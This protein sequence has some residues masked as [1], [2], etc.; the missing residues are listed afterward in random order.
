MRL[1]ALVVGAVV[2]CGPRDSDPV[3]QPPAPDAG[4]PLRGGGGPSVA[5][6]P[7]DLWAPCAWLTGSPDD[8]DHHNLVM[9]YRGHLVLPWA[10][11][12]S[13]GGLSF[14]DVSDPCAP[15]KA[16][17]GHDPQ[18][19]E[20]HAIGF[21]HLPD[22][23]SAGDWAFVNDLQGM[24]TWDVTDLDA[25]ARVGRAIPTNEDGDPIALYPDSYTRVVLSLFLQY[26]WV[27]LASAD[28]GV[29]VVD[30]SDPADPQVVHQHVFDPPLRAGGVFALGN[31]LLVSSA[32]GS[33]AEVLDISDPARPQ[34][35]PGGRF[36][37]TGADGVAAEA[38]HGNLS[39]NLALF[40][41]KSG[42]GGV[43]VY[44]ISDPER[45]TRLGEVRHP[46]GNGGYV[47]Y[48]E[49]FL[50]T[51]ESSFGSVLDARDLSAITEV[52][53]VVIEG[54]LDT[55][56]PYG[57]V[58]IAAVDDKPAQVDGVGLASGVFP[59]SEAVDVTGPV[60]LAVDPP[61]GRVGVP[62]TGRIGVGFNEPVEPSTAHPG[63]IRV[64]SES[65]VWVEGFVSAQEGIANF[66]PKEPLQPDT[67]YVVQVMGGGVTDIN[68]NAVADTSITTFRTAP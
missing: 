6:A 1:W 60:V 22:G 36:T 12:W 45:P 64:I 50:F 47:F 5:F 8:W 24:Q 56:T 51:G 7:D 57:N 30:A 10:P 2:G 46:D 11:E 17:E 62:V 4:P 23:P 63:S 49:G 35:I 68:G 40:A 34:P 18:M 66:S 14:F 26:P 32:E 59:W 53:R 19:R 15:V 20:T 61:N 42:G 48:D 55:V 25:I 67:N 16:A 37:L 13:S 65:G 33:S 41:R 58:L 38:Y 21:L 54:D 28:N 44:D 27:Y 43:L 31:K 52:G 29:F 39:G 3:Y 9:P